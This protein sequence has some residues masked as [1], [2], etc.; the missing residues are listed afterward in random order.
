MF[1]FYREFINC[2]VNIQINDIRQVPIIIPSPQQL[3]NMEVA[4]IKAIECRVA[5][6]RDNKSEL[7]TETLVKIEN[8]IDCFVNSIYLI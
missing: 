3:R 8:D 7:D 6:D 4:V 5:S 2:S 1:E